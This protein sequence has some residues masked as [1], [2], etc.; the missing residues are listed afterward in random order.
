MAGIALT[1]YNAPDLGGAIRL[2]LGALDSQ[3]AREHQMIQEARIRQEMARKEREDQRQY[4]QSQRRMK[5]EEDKFAYEQRMGLPGGLDWMKTMSAVAQ[6]NAQTRQ[7]NVNADSMLP[8]GPRYQ[9]YESQIRENEA[10]AAAA[11][12]QAGLYSRRAENPE[13]FMRPS[14]APRAQGLSAAERKINLEAW[15]MGY[16]PPFPSD[17]SQAPAA[18]TDPMQGMTGYSGDAEFLEDGSSAY[19]PDDSLLPS[20]GPPQMPAAAASPEQPGPVTAPP[21]AQR[22]G[23]Q[24][25]LRQRAEA[26]Q[27]A[28]QDRMLAQYEREVADRLEK[29]SRVKAINAGNEEAPEVKTAESLWREAENRLQQAR[30]R[31]GSSAGSTDT[32][33][34]PAAGATPAPRSTAAKYFSD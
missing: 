22:D 5:L 32:P 10:Q 11:Q 12:A 23:Y 2:T 18:A 3:L 17:S 34:P 8:G 27:A 25:V 21:A 14:A 7:I 9:A 13:A 4:E 19:E 31:L 16:P 30:K 33:P 6:N 28:D 1:P 15:Q 20:S 26:K 29:Y 24:A